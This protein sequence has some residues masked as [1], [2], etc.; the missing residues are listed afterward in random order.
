MGKRRRIN[1]PLYFFA[2][3]LGM[4]GL[5]FGLPVRTL[6]AFPWNLIGL[7]PLAVGF[8]LGLAGMRTFKRAG[9]TVKPFEESTALITGGVFNLT[10][11]PLY[12]SL[13]LMLVGLA[14]LFGSLTPWALVPPFALLMH[15]GFIAPEERLLEEEFGE[16]YLAY[17]R[18]VRRWL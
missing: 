15:R 14:A 8:W 4:A 18:R 7:A 12:L 6:L 1:P 17:K 2:A 10:R 16:E 3:V 9:T 13:T 11:N 5:H